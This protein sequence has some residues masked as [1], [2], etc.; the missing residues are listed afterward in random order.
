M[1]IHLK[2]LL[3]TLLTLT[4]VAIGTVA[5]CFLFALIAWLYEIVKDWEYWSLAFLVFAVMIIFVFVYLGYVFELQ[6]DEKFRENKLK[7]DEISEEN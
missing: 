4:L 6:C 2:A 7:S 5:I 3:H 1:K